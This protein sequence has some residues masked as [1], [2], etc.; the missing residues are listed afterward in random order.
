LAVSEHHLHSAACEGVLFAE[1]YDVAV[2]EARS[3]LND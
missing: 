1:A 3:P 2:A